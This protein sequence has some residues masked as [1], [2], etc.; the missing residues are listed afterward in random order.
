[1]SALFVC[2]AA[3][4]HGVLH[5][6]PTRRSSDLA[7]RVALEQLAGGELLEPARI[8]AVPVILLLV[9][10]GPGQR[11]LAGVDH[12][13]E[14]AGVDVGRVLDR[15]STRLNSSHVKISYAVFCLNKKKN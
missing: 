5:P 1:P 9:E 4:A 7:G 15:K 12:D 8:P 11:H 6:F 10:L 3:G 2:A 14:I 13:D